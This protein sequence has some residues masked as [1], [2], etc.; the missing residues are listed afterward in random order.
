MKRFGIAVVAAVV[1]LVFL[2]G[3]VNAGCIGVETGTD[4]GCGDTVWESCT[5]NENL[6]CPT[7]HGLVIGANG[8]II[9]GNGYT[10]DG[11]SPGACDGS[12]TQRTGIYNKAHDDVVIKNLEIKNFCNGI[13]FKYDSEEGDRVDRVERVVIENCNIHHNGGDSGG[14]NSVHGIKAIGMFDSTIKNCRIH[15]N[16]GKGMGC[17]D[18]GNGIFLK[19]ISGFGAWNNTITHNEIY[20]NRKGGFFTKMMCVD[21]EVSY[22]R[23]WGNGQGGIILRCKMSAT[24]D[25]HHNNV[26]CNY[27]DGIFVGGPDNTIRDNVVNNN[28]AGFKIS[29][30]DKVG[31]G[32]GI[33]MGRSDGSY[34]NEL[35]YNTVCGNEGTDI[36]TYGSGSG[37]TGD[38]NTCDTTENYDD[39]GAT[40]CTYTC[41]PGVIADFSAEPTKGTSPLE[42][43]FID[44]SKPEGDITGWLWDFGDGNTSNEQNPVHA[45]YTTEPYSY[46]NV[47]LTVTGS[48]EASDT[49]TK[50]DYIKVWRED[51][52][53]NADFICSKGVGDPSVP[54]QFTDKSLGEV[55]SWLYEFGD[56]G[57][58]STQNPE[59][60]YYAEG[61]Y[62]VSLTVEGA[63]GSSKETKFNCT[64][65]GSGTG[66]KWPLIDAHFF[67]SA[68]RGTAPFTVSFTDMSRSEAEIDSWRWD[69][70]DGNTSSEVN[71]THTY[72][73]AG[74]YNV[75]LE[76]TN[77]VGAKSREMKIGYIVVSPLFTDYFDTGAPANPYPSIFGTHKG[78]I[79]PDRDITVN[80]MYTYPCMG[81]GGHT[82]YV[83]IWNESEGIEGVGHWSG[84]QG[85]YHNITISPA[86]TLLKNHEYNYII[87]TGSYPQIIH[88][89]EKAVEGGIITCTEFKDANGRGYNNWIP[90]IRLWWG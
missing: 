38:N 87:R 55:T 70:G 37:T 62:T 3:S 79:I 41:G 31:D 68:R 66:E 60:C 52:A 27:G 12:G 20:E 76:V 35:Y 82:E 47:S 19:G 22:N 4:F 84:Y 81:T 11:V 44:R 24:H 26:S 1:F 29:P 33:D 72:S 21:T 6:I 13:Y 53:P 30:E 50:T 69:F 75:S 65:V 85:D 56:G 5:F 14:D 90:A 58:N 34:N 10:L 28:I 78:K 59:H 16:T 32:D 86:I 80:K 40:G 23:V 63:G 25:I 71:P 83:R 9:D 88:A 2:I 18:G 8:I 43:T 61:V 51:A 15:H 64:R 74:I 42:V 77:I 36:D 54:V 57:T 7:G 17:D 46:Y 49:V 39:E 73:S 67:A 89:R 48:G 45:Y